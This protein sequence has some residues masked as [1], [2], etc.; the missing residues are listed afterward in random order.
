MLIAAALA[1]SHWPRVPVNFPFGPDV[2]S[3]I[4]LSNCFKLFLLDQRLL[5]SFFIFEPWL[6]LLVGSASPLFALCLA[7]P[8]DFAILL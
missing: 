6:G 4:K 8:Q 7:F 1:A 2:T 3:A 5:K